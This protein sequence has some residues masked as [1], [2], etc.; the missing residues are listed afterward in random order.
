MSERE[1]KEITDKDKEWL[2][3]EAIKLYKGKKPGNHVG[4]F[5]ECI[6]D[7][8]QPISDVFTHHRSVSSCHLSNI[9][10]LLGRKLRWNLVEEDFIGDDEA[11]K[12]LSRKQRKPYTIEQLTS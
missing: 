11:S 12:M 9:A 5:F 7:R 4:N 8:S 10:M 2:D 1:S 3:Q 6:K